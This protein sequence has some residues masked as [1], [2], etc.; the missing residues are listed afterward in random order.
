[1]KEQGRETETERMREREITNCGI[2]YAL[3]DPFALILPSSLTQ[4]IIFHVLPEPIMLFSEQT[5]TY[6]G[7][8]HNYLWDKRKYNI[9]Y[10]KGG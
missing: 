8:I 4:C 5:H 2:V 9:M 1:M 10:L 3:L 7:Y 6:F